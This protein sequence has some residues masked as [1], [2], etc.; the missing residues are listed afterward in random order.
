MLYMESLVDGGAGQIDWMKTR[1]SQRRGRNL[2]ELAG[3]MWSYSLYQL[4]NNMKFVY[5]AMLFLAFTLLGCQS[6]SEK[7]SEET[8]REEFAPDLTPPEDDGSLVVNDSTIEL[9]LDQSGETLKTNIEKEYQRIEIVVP[10]VQTDSLIGH[11]TLPGEQRNIY[12]S[13]IS[14]PDNET[15]GPFGKEIRYATSKAGTY[16]VTVSPNTRASGTIVG[17]VEIKIDLK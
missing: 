17:P 2:D 3:F 14:M 11:L 6:S 16:I 4:V 7:Q 1:K 12:F 9:Q 13:E 5:F 8:A 15:D 10:N